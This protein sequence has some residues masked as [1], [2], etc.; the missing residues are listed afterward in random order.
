MIET[1]VGLAMPLKKKIVKVDNTIL[2]RVMILKFGDA[3][4]VILMLV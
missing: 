4:N 3:L 1:T 2:D